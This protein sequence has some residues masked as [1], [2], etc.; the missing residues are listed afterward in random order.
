MGDRPRALL[1]FLLPTGLA[2]AIDLALRGGA[3]AAYALQGKAIYLSSMLVSAALWAL[4]LSVTAEL[5]ATAGPARPARRVALAAL[6]GLWV[7]PFATLGYGGQVL[8]YRVFHSYM[9]RDTLRLGIALRG[10]VRDWFA[11]WGGPSLLA[12]ML[13]AGV[14][15]TYAALRLSRAAATGGRA[16][17]PL[18]PAATFAAAV[19]VLWIDGVDSRFLQAA[20]PDVCFA[21][22]VVHLTRMA[23][24]G[25]WTR[26]QGVSMR[27]PAPLP[28]LTRAPRTDAARGRPPDL[29]LI[30]T[31]S[32]RAD[33]LCSARGE[34]GPP[35][36]TAPFLDLVVPDRI[37]LGKLTS[38]TPNTFSA[39][40]ILWSGVAPNAD[41]HAAHTAP[42][43]WELARAVGYRTAYLSAQNPDYEDF[44]V[45]T[46]NAG[47]D[48]LVTANDL[49]GMGQEQLGAPDERAVDAALQ[50]VRAVPTA[51]PYFAV[52]HLSNTHMPYRIDPALAPFTPQS[53][54]ALG[55]VVAFHNR[56]LDA[57]RLQ[58]R[59]VAG[60]L[61]ALRASPR[62]DDTAVL[63]VS[64]HGEQF[65]E[66]GGLYHNHSLFDEEVR[67]PGWLAAGARVLGD[68]ERAAL[69]TY[70]GHRTYTAD[71]HETMVDLLGLEEQ[72][73][74]LPLASLVTGR[75]LLRP[76]TSDPM[77]LLAT[78]TSVW[79]PDDARFGVMQDAR[80]LF[81]GATGGWRCF[82]L[83]KD[84]GEHSPRT[85][86]WCPELLGVARRE[87]EG[88]ATPR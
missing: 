57:V 4:P 74:R 59:T 22:S 21:H 5:V 16:G 17:V 53:A 66:H 70:A 44:G 80:L 55:D 72:R 86:D 41:L 56:Y 33:A 68:P 39:S 26:R 30:I 37:A 62:W 45:F 49:G 13:A 7:L 67:V 51:T 20:T 28:P 73:A 43:L 58:E 12:A 83:E 60:L 50:F 19:V 75:S 31:E 85:A 25:Q 78:S 48:T 36:C 81:G 14:A 10:T 27:T 87:F 46:R 38:Q 40:V 6:L 2:L 52:V 84:P 88:V 29:V 8:Y 82:D 3:L 42:V 61:A 64:D 15:L 71:V 24:T 18:L 32:V 23:L 54:D 1:L 34:G 77:T 76:R 35:G 47:I 69:A 9:G 11:A 63:F 65:R 79:E